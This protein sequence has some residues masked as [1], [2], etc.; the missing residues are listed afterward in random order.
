MSG[1]KIRQM[2]EEKIKVLYSSSTQSS[3]VGLR[4]SGSAQF[5]SDHL[6]NSNNDLYIPVAHTKFDNFQVILNEI[7]GDKLNTSWRPYDEKT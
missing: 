4:N 5:G 2:I 6:Q 1:F 7:F 3:R